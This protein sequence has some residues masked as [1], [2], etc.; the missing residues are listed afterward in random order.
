M[1]IVRQES[2]LIIGSIHFHGK[3]KLLTD[4][5]H[6]LSRNNVSYGD[7]SFVF[8]H[9]RQI[10]LAGLLNRV[11]MASFGKNI[12]RQKSETIGVPNI[13]STFN[14]VPRD[15]STTAALHHCQANNVAQK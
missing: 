15:E 14:Y 9:E 3:E 6:P 10:N 4:V 5:V 13:D 7:S 2:L 11:P 8:V 12:T 1:K